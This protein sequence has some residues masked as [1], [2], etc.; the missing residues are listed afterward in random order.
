MCVCERERE[1]KQGWLPN[2]RKVN[3]QYSLPHIITRSS[4]HVCVCVWCVVCTHRTKRILLRTSAG[5]IT[6]MGANVDNDEEDAT[7]AAD[8]EE[9]LVRGFTTLKRG[10]VVTTETRGWL[11]D[12]TDEDDAELDLFTVR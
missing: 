1:S 12:T 6:V 4:A 5:D 7:V 8:V 9:E 2:T 11:E 10:A 3:V